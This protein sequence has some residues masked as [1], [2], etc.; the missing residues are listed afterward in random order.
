MEVPEEPT[1]VKKKMGKPRTTNRLK[2]DGSYDN[3]PC[4]PHYFRDYYRNKLSMK[5]ACELCG[6]EVAKGK[7]TRHKKSVKCGLAVERLVAQMS[8]NTSGVDAL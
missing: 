2:E 6:S 4:D 7:M 3:K 5:C 8:P 1:Q